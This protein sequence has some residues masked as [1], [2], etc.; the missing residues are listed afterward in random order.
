MNTTSTSR[1]S[2]DAHEPWRVI[3]VGRTGLDQSLR[4]DAQ[5]EL[6]RCRE[7]IE[8]IGELGDPIDHESPSQPVVIVSPDAIGEETRER[9]QF[10][11]ALRLINP[12]VRVLIVNEDD[13]AFDASI[14]RDQP[15]DDL[16]DT[17]ARCIDEQEPEPVSL[18][19]ID[20]SDLDETTTDQTS[21]QTDEAADQETDEEATDEESTEDRPAAEPETPAKP[22][23]T[24]VVDNET[25]EHR[26]QRPF[27]EEDE[28]HKQIVMGITPDQPLPHTTPHTHA[29]PVVLDDEPLVR[30][31][32]QGKSM[33][34]PA[35]AQINTRLGR[36]DIDLIQSD[37]AGAAQGVPVV[38]AD[39]TVGVLSCNDASW[40][41]GVG[42]SL[43]STHAGWLASWIKLEA[44]QSELRRCAFTDSL[45]GAWNRRYFERFLAAAIDQSRL[46]RRPLTVMIFDIDS[47]KHY[48][49]TYGHAA[50]DE[51]LAETVKLLKSVIRPSDRVCRVGGDEFAVIF[52]EPQG[53]RDPSSKPLE[54]IY[55]IAKR[56]QKQVCQHRFPKL[57][58][59]AMG[60]LTISGGLASY[61]WDGH[62]AAS[63]LESADQCAME[64]KRQGKNAI[65]L[66][67]GAESVCHTEH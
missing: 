1:P 20:L 19:F 59:E 66:G 16:V 15:L 18:R 6:I 3:L 47:F 24:V 26:A 35:I 13:N 39:K 31:M 57:G 30:A 12:S 62:D 33:L 11:N 56:F 53:P 42:R 14:Q 37:A 67:P 10:V 7:T 23:V 50:G 48:N 36:S 4:R 61:P 64:S 52:Y 5:I 63:L 46:A 60:T 29:T 54:S 49:D 55:Q 17:I 58:A 34:E 45:T 8:A 22:E 32:L 65:S 2:P 27:E 43:L 41:N 9:K 40:L 38:V 44:Q 25:F 51:I 21:V 28:L